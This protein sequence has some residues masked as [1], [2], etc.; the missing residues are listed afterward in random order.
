[1]AAIIKSPDE[2]E[3][4]RVA[5]KLAAEVL[6]MITP[7]VKKGVTTDELNTLCHDFIVNEQKAIP[8]PLNYGNPPFPKS[9]CISVTKLVTGTQR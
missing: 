8:A 5:G 4:M 9:V 3:K 7:H 2:I 1:M 6:T